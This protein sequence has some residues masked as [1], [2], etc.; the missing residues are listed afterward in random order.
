MKTRKGYGEIFDRLADVN[1]E[2][3]EILNDLKTLRDDMDEKQ[4]VL[5]SVGME[6]DVDITDYEYAPKVMDSG[7]DSEWEPKY[8]ELKKKYIDRFYKGDSEGEVEE[9]EEEEED[10]NEDELSVEDLLKGE[11]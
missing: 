7:N 6:Y 2:N 5:D 11:E 1:F 9:E 10:E 8:R 4:D 3:E